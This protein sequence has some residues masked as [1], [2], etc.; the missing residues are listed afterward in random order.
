MEQQEVE[1][2]R[3]SLT[4]T[5]KHPIMPERIFYIDCEQ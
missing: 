2:R 1:T 3:S 4:E 5:A